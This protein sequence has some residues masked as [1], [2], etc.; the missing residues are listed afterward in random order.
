V[1]I[2]HGEHI[3]QPGDSVIAVTGVDKEERLKK[4]L[5]S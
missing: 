2:P 5:T 3:L 1:I 4:I